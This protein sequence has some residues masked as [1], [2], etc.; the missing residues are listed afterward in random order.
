MATFRV[1]DRKIVLLFNVISGHTYQALH[2]SSFVLNLR[3][4]NLSEQMLLLLLFGLVE[5]TSQRDQ[6]GRFFKVLG[7]HLSCKNSPNILLLF[8]HFENNKFKL[9]AVVA[10]F[11]ATLGRSFITLKS[12]I[13]SHWYQPTHERTIGRH[14]LNQLFLS[15]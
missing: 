15:V 7:V 10:T 8:G 14:R 11:L 1:T 4:F 3:V 13:W 12:N 6:I 2:L 9:E 5:S